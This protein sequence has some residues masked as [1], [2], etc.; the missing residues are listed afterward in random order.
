MCVEGI[1]I[2][3]K[4]MRWID[5]AGFPEFMLANNGMGDQTGNNPHLEVR[6]LP[7]FPKLVCVDTAGCLARMAVGSHG[8]VDRGSWEAATENG[9]IET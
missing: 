1:G 8:L 2:R 6:S 4:T 7:E 3:K 5:G 9:I